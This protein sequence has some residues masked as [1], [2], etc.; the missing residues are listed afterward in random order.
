M[1]KTDREKAGYYLVSIYIHKLDLFYVALSGLHTAN[2]SWQTRVGKLRKVDKLFP[3]QVKLVSNNNYSC[4]VPSQRIVANNTLFMRN[5]NYVLERK[6]V[7]RF[8]E[9]PGIEVIKI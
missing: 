3:S 5:W 1:R 7:D 6:M 4:V 8:P 2:L 9:L